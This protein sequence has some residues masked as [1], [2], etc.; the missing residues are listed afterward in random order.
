VDLDTD[1]PTLS[2]L[3]FILV[4]GTN[5]RCFSPESHLENAQ[6][7]HMSAGLRELPRSENGVLEG[8]RELSRSRPLQPNLARP[9]A[10]LRQ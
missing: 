10:E 2:G 9:T 8:D 7:K 4:N 3:L 5:A 1:E 6:R